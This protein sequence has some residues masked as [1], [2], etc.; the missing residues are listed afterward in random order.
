MGNY[1]SSGPFFMSVTG[2]K[3]RQFGAGRNM[4][5]SQLGWL[6]GK[7]KK[8]PEKVWELVHFC[9]I[10]F[11]EKP[12]LPHWFLSS[13]SHAP[14]L[15]KQPF[16]ASSFILLSISV[17]PLLPNTKFQPSIQGTVALFFRLCLFTTVI[18]AMK[19]S[20]CQP[21]LHHRSNDIFEKMGI[22]VTLE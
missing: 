20:P 21:L 14:L 22:L 4:T 1:A 12:F 8:D 17:E 2:H 9:L 6:S 13:V 10:C 3:Y 18:W 11:Q 15:V 19:T 16:S 7:Q 5:G